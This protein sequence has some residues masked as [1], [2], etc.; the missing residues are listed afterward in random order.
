MGNKRKSKGKKKRR[1][2]G[3]LERGTSKRKK[4]R[5]KKKNKGAEDKA[6]KDGTRKNLGEEWRHLSE[7]KGGKEKQGR[8]RETR[9]QEV[10]KR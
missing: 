10:E 5:K 7:S 2:L 3:V 9:K 4:P 8:L 1:R 6:K